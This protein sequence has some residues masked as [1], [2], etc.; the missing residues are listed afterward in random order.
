[1]DEQPSHAAARILLVV[2]AA[3][4]ADALGRS[5]T[6]LGYDLLGVAVCCDQA[7]DMAARLAPDLA[8][9]DIQLC[10]NVDALETSALLR[11]CLGLPV[12]FLADRVD[13]TI[14]GRMGIAC[15]YGCLVSPFRDSELLA[16]VETALYQA[17]RTRQLVARECWMTTSLNSME[18][19]LLAADAEE[20]VRFVNPTGQTLLGLDRD[21]I[22]GRPFDAVYT[23]ESETS[24][25]AL[26]SHQGR[27]ECL[28]VR[29]DGRRLPV[30][31]TR[32]PI[33]D[34]GGAHFGSLVVF[35][36]ISQ[37]RRDEHSLRQSLEN[38]RRTLDQTVNALTVTS[39][40]RDPFTA[41]HQQRVS[42]LAEA[43]ARELGLSEEAREGV[44]VAGL[45][46]D[47]GKVYVPS[48]ILANSGT[49]SSLEMDI[50]RQHSE[51]GY[52]I[53]KDV[54][55]PWPVARMVLEHHERLD[56]SGYPAGLVAPAIL[57]ESRILAVADVVEAMTAHRPYRPALGMDQA[58]A[59]IRL[60]RGVRYDP[61][62]V[63]VCILLCQSGFCF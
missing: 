5:L 56:G 39:E 36:D 26:V 62:V 4:K 46:H 27:V 49:L 40:Q 33:L 17:R 28:L 23:T 19:G 34:A 8:L 35:R 38:L 47:I 24:P 60:G 1:M 41:G 22:L 18:E 16:T 31:Q 53:L 14:L 10:G 59:E 50:I 2:D 30:E 21:Q 45:V 32:S 20:L 37:R 44:R 25:T 63:D 54:P 12:V 13:R 15:A 57:P 55:F 58:L 11:E 9:V 51:V 6:R 42:Q 3:D 48:E 43:I 61:D 29:A 7:L 52:E